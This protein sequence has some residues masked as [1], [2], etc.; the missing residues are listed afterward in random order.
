MVYRTKLVNFK[1]NIHPSMSKNFVEYVSN[2]IEIL[3]YHGV[4]YIF[5]RTVYSDAGN[6]IKILTI[7]K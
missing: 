5:P 7:V 2:F 3:W 6:L 4:S 1:G